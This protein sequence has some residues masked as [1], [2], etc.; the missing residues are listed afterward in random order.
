MRKILKSGS[1]QGG[2]IQA[3]RDPFPLHIA[4]GSI[5]VFFAA[6][7][8]EN[9]QV[10]SAIGHAVI[11]DPT[12]LDEVRVLPPILPPDTSLYNQIELPNGVADDFSDR[13]FTLP[14]TQTLRI[15]P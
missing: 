4:D 2:T 9:G 12:K 6:K 1:K 8:K 15:A 14:E 10:V 11:D 13:P 7:K 3:L 5:H